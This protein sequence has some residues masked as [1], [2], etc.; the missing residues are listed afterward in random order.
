MAL[1][2][3]FTTSV[4]AIPAGFT[5]VGIQQLEWDVVGDWHTLLSSSL[6]YNGIFGRRFHPDLA[7][8]AGFHC[9]QWHFHLPEIPTVLPTHKILLPHPKIK[10]CDGFWEVAA[11]QQWL[12][13]QGF[14]RREVVM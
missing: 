7:I 4:A 9:D 6:L 2:L 1:G 14:I 8:L 12:K 10:A 3:T 11:F 13:G 5:L